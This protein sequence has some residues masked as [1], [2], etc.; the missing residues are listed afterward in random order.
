M[1]ISYQKD[2]RRKTSQKTLL[3]FFVMRTKKPKLD[4]GRCNTATNAPLTSPYFSSQWLQPLDHVY[5]P[6]TAN[7]EGKTGEYIQLKPEEK[8]KV[9]Y[10]KKANC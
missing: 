7:M 4:N 3:S 8:I 10:V 1:N 2:S 9:L 6:T 5:D